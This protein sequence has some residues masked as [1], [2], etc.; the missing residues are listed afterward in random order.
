MVNFIIVED[1]PHHMLKT[2]EIVINYM[3]KNNFE[4]DILLTAI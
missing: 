2:K 3:M 4:F 1:N